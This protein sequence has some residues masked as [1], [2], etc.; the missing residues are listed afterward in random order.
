MDKKIVGLIGAVTV[1]VAPEAAQ[2][3]PAAT[4]SID[5]VMSVQSYAELLDPI[6][7]ARAL[8]READAV[9]ASRPARVEKTQYYDH[10]HHHH[11]QYGPGWGGGYGYGYR[12]YHHHHHHHHHNGFW[13]NG[14][15]GNGY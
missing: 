11:N 2:A 9:A 10:H 14:F 1:F 13:G 8:L 4:P 3:L 12:Y 7:N 6:P 5:E 15:W